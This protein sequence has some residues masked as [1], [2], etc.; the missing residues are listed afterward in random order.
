MAFITALFMRAVMPEPGAPGED[1]PDHRVVVERRIQAAAD[2]PHRA[3]APRRGDRVGQEL[4]SVA[5]R[6]HRSLTKP[7][8]DDDRHPHPGIGLHL[9]AALAPTGLMDTQH[10][11]RRW[12][13]VDGCDRFGVGDERAVRDRPAHAVL[14][15]DIGHRP[16]VIAKWPR[17]PVAA[18]GPSTATGPGCLAVIG[19][20]VFR[21][22]Q[23]T[24]QRHFCSRHTRIG[25]SGPIITSM[26]VSE[27]TGQRRRPSGRSSP[28]KFEE[29][30]CDTFE[31]CTDESLG[32]L[33]IDRQA[34][35]DGGVRRQFTSFE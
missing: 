5:G 3:G 4:P 26:P 14:G 11:H 1:H 12:R 19:V 20:N 16:G 18:A 2:R 34:E 17:R 13:T 25:T 30:Y 23:A 21:S 24:V 22:H 9:V 28:T 8:P 29:P 6:V 33:V 7:V 35:E 32:W 31:L 15:G 27:T 10:G